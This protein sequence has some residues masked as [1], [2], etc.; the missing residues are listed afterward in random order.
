MSYI[1]KTKTT[2][3]LNTESTYDWENEAWSV[4]INLSVLQLIKVGDQLLQV[5]GGVRYWVDTPAGGPEDWGFNLTF[6]ML[7]PK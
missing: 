1:T 7:F 3:V 2:I 6:T 4:P 5:G